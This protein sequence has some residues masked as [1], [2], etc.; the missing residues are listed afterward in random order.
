M[1]TFSWSMSPTSDEHGREVSSDSTLGESESPMAFG[2]SPVFREFSNLIRLRSPIIQYRFHLTLQKEHSL[3]LSIYPFRVELNPGCPSNRPVAFS[4]SW[5]SIDLMTSAP[6]T[7]QCDRFREI[8]TICVAP[9]REARMLPL[10]GDFRLHV[11]ADWRFS[12][13]STSGG[14][15]GVIRE[16]RASVSPLSP[17]IVLPFSASPELPLGTRDTRAF[18]DCGSHLLRTSVQKASLRE[19]S[20]PSPHGR[21]FAHVAAA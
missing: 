18:C 7:R 16:D 6:N 2:E 11:L 5:R 10:L 14:F 12:G 21:F 1:S 9:R 4:F 17:F 13:I 19:I 20:P 8:T 3:R 15:G